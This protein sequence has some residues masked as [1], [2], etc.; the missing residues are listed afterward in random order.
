MKKLT[1]LL[2]VLS[3]NSFA[4]VVDKDAY[5]CLMPETVQAINEAKA[6]SDTYR[7]AAL[8]DEECVEIDEGTSVQVVSEGVE[9][10]GIHYMGDTMW[11]DDDVLEDF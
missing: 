2:T 10:S 5:A 8:L 6:M 4:E 1:L 11:I 9:V 3:F 7:V